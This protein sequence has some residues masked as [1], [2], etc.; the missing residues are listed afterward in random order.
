VIPPVLVGGFVALF[1]QVV[2]S[3]SEIALTVLGEHVEMDLGALDRTPAALSVVFA[4][5][6]GVEAVRRRSKPAG[7][8]LSALAVSAVVM[9]GVVMTVTFGMKEPVEWWLCGVLGAPLVGATAGAPVFRFLGMWAPFSWISRVLD[10]SPSL[11]RRSAIVPFA[12]LAVLALAAPVALVFL[13][14]LAVSL[15]RAVAGRRTLWVEGQVAP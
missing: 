15:A 8:I 4:F 11:A 10:S 6:G 12:I 3:M 1:G 2:G 14:S 9:L 5:V 7:R 13:V